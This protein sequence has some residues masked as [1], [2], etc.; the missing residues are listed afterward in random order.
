MSLSLEITQPLKYSTLRI[1]R[2]TCQMYH[3]DV[4]SE[5][6]PTMTIYYFH[7]LYRKRRSTSHKSKIL[8]LIGLY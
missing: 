7:H 3:N 4:F 1:Y 2:F 8:Y 5:N 6:L